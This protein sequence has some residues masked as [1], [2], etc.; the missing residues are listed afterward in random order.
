MPAVAESLPPVDLSTVLLVAFCDTCERLIFVRSLLNDPRHLTR[1]QGTAVTRLLYDGL[2]CVERQLDS[3]RPLV[4]EPDHRGRDRAPAGIGIAL[5]ALRQVHAH[6]GLLGTRWQLGTIDL[7]VRKL[8]AE[9]V[10]VLVPT[11]CP[12][13]HV[14]AAATEVGERF[15]QSLI[16]CGLAVAPVAGDSPILAI[17]TMDLIDPLSWA[18]HLYPLSAAM[19][20]KRGFDLQLRGQSN[21]DPA[22]YRQLCT[23]DFAARLVGEATFAACAARTLLERFC[24]AGGSVDIEVL[25]AASTRY[26]RPIGHSSARTLT[27]FFTDIL[28]TQSTLQSAWGIRPPS[29]A[30]TA[31]SIDWSDVD[32]FIGAE[33]PDPVL[34]SIEEAETLYELLSDGRPINARPPALPGAFEQRLTDAVDAAEFYKLLPVADERPCSLATILVVGW[35][36]KVR[37]THPLCAELMS[38]TSS[39]RDAIDALASH[40]LERCGLL[41]QSIEAAYVQQIFSTLGNR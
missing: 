7:F 15:K 18:A 1:R 31:R 11:L 5:A 33:V 19:V 4:F 27:G 3:I 36:Y 26:Q 23:A 17:P 14:D 29:P 34:P 30:R 28:E 12:S 2:D 10:S 8:V 35:Q 22:A 13:D 21:L 9:G 16:A 41:Q 39:W 20:S 6:L 32:A 25:G 38:A 24:G 40:V 37:R